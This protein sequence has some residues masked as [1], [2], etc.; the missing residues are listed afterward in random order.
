MHTAKI[1]LKKKNYTA[2]TV[3]V[4]TIIRAHNIEGSEQ[5]TKTRWCFDE[6]EMLFPG[7]L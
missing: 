6:L 1:K 3:L 7:V 4:T 5:S 2:I